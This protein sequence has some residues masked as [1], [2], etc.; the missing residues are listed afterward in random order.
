MMEEVFIKPGFAWFLE[1]A[2]IQDN[3]MCV[4]L[5]VHDHPQAIKIHSHEMKPE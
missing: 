3:G 5:F 1:I 4:G 2:F